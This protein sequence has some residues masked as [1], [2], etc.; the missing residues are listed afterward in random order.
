MYVPYNEDVLRRTFS[1]LHAMESSKYT[2]ETITEPIENGVRNNLAF[3]ESIYVSLWAISS[4]ICDHGGDSDIIADVYPMLYEAYLGCG[5]NDE[6]HQLYDEIVNFENQVWTSICVFVAAQAL[7]GGVGNENTL[8]WR[9]MN[10]AMD[11]EFK[12]ERASHKAKELALVV[13]S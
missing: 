10:D 11:I 7:E 8:S 6:F 12:A 3:M 9:E 1:M 13:S 2:D 5:L 4:D